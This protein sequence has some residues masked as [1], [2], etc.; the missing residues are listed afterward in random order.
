MTV[1]GKESE[2]HELNQVKLGLVK[3]RQ[4]CWSNFQIVVRSDQLINLSFR[5][6]SATEI[7]QIEMKIQ[8]AKFF[9]IML[10]IFLSIGMLVHN[11]AQL[12]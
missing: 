10:N 2:V 8:S 12:V 6:V 1:V 7:Q 11:R 9:E 3:L 4:S 5:T